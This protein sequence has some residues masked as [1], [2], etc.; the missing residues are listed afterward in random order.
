MVEDVGSSLNLS[1]IRGQTPV[2][3]VCHLNNMRVGGVAVRKRISPFSTFDRNCMIIRI[4]GPW[5]GVG[6][7]DAR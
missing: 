1:G 5:K 2:L 3:W 6:V 7:G 4:S